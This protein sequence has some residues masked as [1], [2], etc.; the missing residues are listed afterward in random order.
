MHYKATFSPSSIFCPTT[1]HFYP[2]E[3]IQDELKNRSM[4]FEKDPEKKKECLKRIEK[5][6]E[7][8][9]E[10][11]IIAY[12]VGYHSY[13]EFVKDCSQEMVDTLNDVLPYL[14]E[15]DSIGYIITSLFVCCMKTIR[16]NKRE[17]IL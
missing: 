12:S 2:Y 10:N 16:E 11:L 14:P 9:K 1:Q 3:E 6:V 4:C 8:L 5:K 17:Y 7:Y 13:K 15:T